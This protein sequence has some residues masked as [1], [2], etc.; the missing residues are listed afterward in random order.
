MSHEPE[1]SDMLPEAETS[2]SAQ[3][4][5]E[6]P[7]QPAFGMGKLLIVIFLAAAAFA[8]VK[9]MPKGSSAPDNLPLVDRTGVHEHVLEILDAARN[10]VIRTPDSATAWGNYGFLLFAHELEQESIDCFIQAE[11]LDG[12]AYQ[13]PYMRGM[14]M[15]LN[16][17]DLE[18]A[19]T[20]FEKAIQLRPDDPSIRITVGD[21]YMGLNRFDEAATQWQYILQRDPTHAWALFGM[22]R[23]AF[24]QGNMN[25]AIDL[26][27]RSL[28][29]DAKIRK[30]H[31]LLTQ[32]YFRQ[33]NQEEARKELAIVET[34][35]DD[36]PVDSL[37]EQVL[38]L[39]QDP[40]FAVVRAK[41]DVQAGNFRAAIERLEPLIDYESHPMEYYYYLA[42]AHAST[43]N[44]PR[45]TEILELGVKR[46]PN[47]SELRRL[48]SKVYLSQNDQAA[49]IEQ[50][51]KGLEIKP[52]AALLYHDLGECYINQNKDD[53]A[54]E[55]WNRA[56]RIRPDSSLTHF[57][58]GKLYHKRG[59]N[60]DASRHLQ[61][62]LK[63][64]PQMTEASTL[65]R[66]IE[67]ANDSQ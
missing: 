4:S 16:G 43:Q 59:K 19:A 33:G 64:A 24:H 63:F 36:L 1:S 57:M 26:A 50:L 10:N 23:I 14:G 67:K 30:V 58:L 15:S 9:F 32:L 54:F 53:H 47:S 6:T 52:D 22:A 46:Q 11:Q 60:K 62:A 20:C 35:P 41:K 49:A 13:W 45:A 28:R 40:A 5:I 55:A 18:T 39:R 65:L 34:L 12:N 44:L 7:A 37:L 38:S 27:K 29:S 31:E 25:E 61:Q 51:K 3:Q 2:D 48:F 56:L 42:T 8:A 21:F 17:L 66:R